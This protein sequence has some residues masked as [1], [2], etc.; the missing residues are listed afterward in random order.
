MVKSNRIVKKEE[1]FVKY[2]N[3][4]I[5]RYI[6][7][8]ILFFLF[9]TL[10]FVFCFDS[11]KKNQDVSNN[12]ITP[13][14]SN[15]INPTLTST[16][17]TTSISTSTPTSTLYSTSILP[18]VTSAVTT[19]TIDS[20]STMVV[21]S[22]PTYT[23]IVT[24]SPQTDISAHSSDII[25]NE[26]MVLNDWYLKQ[27]DDKYYDWVE[28]KNISNKNIDLSDYVITDKK[29]KM[30]YNLPKV[31]LKPNQLYVIICSDKHTGFALNSTMDNLFLYD[32]SG[33]LIDQVHL[34]NIPYGCSYGRM[35][36]EKTFYYFTKPTPLSKNTSGIKEIASE[37]VSNY[38]SG[39]YNLNSLTVEFSSD[40]IIYYTMDGTEPTTKSPVLS[41]PIIINE[42]TVIRTLV[43]EKGKLPS[44]ITTFSY[45][46]NPDTTLPVLSLVTAPDNLWDE[47]IGIYVKGKYDNYFQDW[48]RAASI[49]YFG[50]DGTFSLNCGLKLNGEGSRQSDEK[51]SFKVLFKGKYG[52]SSL[53]CNLFD[54]GIDEY[55]SLVIRAGEDYRYSVFRN[56]MVV[57]YAKKFFP[58]LVTRDGKYCSLFINGEYFGIYYLMERITEKFISEK[59][60]VEE[61]EVIIEDFSPEK[62]GELEAI[63]TFCRTNDM[64]IKSNYDYISSKIDIES[65]TDWFILQAYSGNTDV[66][67][68]LKYVKLG[69]SGK[70][71]W[72]AHDFDWSFYAHEYPFENVLVKGLWYTSY[73]IKPMLKNADYKQYFIERFAYH[74]KNT[75][76]E[77]ANLISI[78]D[79]LYAIIEPEIA[80]ERARWGGTI[81]S[82]KKH[83]NEI[84]S[85]VV[86][87]NRCQELIDSIISVFSLSQEDINKYFC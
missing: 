66:T 76:N 49:S 17:T 12:S 82:W 33:V 20:D 47:E 81:E 74:A 80:K 2:F 38:S 34:E 31:V 27:I 67:Q 35:D 87:Y 44:K 65:M 1:S 29:N 77:P 26:V 61:N 71:K 30:K 64:S 18:Y 8:K 22:T 40:G 37:A 52:A 5:N 58:S 78:I 69:S 43:E 39:V 24:S 75:F 16:T 28:I 9:A 42:N 3:N 53:K 62:G 11:C 86:D 55:D 46:L 13:E 54:N 48:E 84:K 51:K 19:S 63:M 10:I 60:N 50:Q 15:I 32:K 72:V 73:I 14:I 36:S 7:V 41:K 25:I 6:I 59:Y 79:E 4:I 70:W 57:A 45:I 85:F 68:N 56:E 21:V 83:V 23:P